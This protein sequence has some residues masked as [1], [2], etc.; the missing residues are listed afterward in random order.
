VTIQQTSLNSF[1]LSDIVVESGLASDDSGS[2][3]EFNIFDNNGLASV[4]LPGVDTTYTFIGNNDP[5]LELSFPDTRHA[6]LQAETIASISAPLLE[7]FMD[8]GRTSIRRSNLETLSLPKLRTTGSYFLV[9]D[10]PY[11]AGID[12]PQLRRIGGSA[13]M[14]GYLSTVSIPNL[15]SVGQNLDISSSASLDCTNLDNTLQ[16][17]NVVQGTYTC[18]SRTDEGTDEG[19]ATGKSSSGLSLGAK[20]G[21]G[22]GVGIVGLAVII[23]ATICLWRRRPQRQQRHH[24]PNSRMHPPTELPADKEGSVH[25]LFTAGPNDYSQQRYFELPDSQRKSWFGTGR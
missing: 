2:S 16:N 3:Y 20:I 6:V 11:L 15:I 4:S 7:T 9:E 12:L 10:N 24:R 23:L 13:T 14:K 21:I 18:E 8:D 25:E 1:D 19:E 22:V 5:S 17:G